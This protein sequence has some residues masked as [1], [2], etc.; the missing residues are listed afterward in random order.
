MLTA[1]TCAFGTC[2]PNAELM[3][4]KLNLAKRV[5]IAKYRCH[6]QEKAKAKQQRKLEWGRTCHTGQHYQN[7]IAVGAHMFDS[8]RQFSARQTSEPD[9]HCGRKQWRHD[10]M[11]LAREARCIEHLAI[12]KASCKQHERYTPACDNAS[13]DYPHGETMTAKPHCL[14]QSLQER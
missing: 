2:I 8:P 12:S 1:S 11:I 7:C 5:H 10:E 3:Y 6:S 14:L 4:D 9:A 13:H